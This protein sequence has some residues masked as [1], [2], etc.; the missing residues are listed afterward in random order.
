LPFIARAP[1]AERFGAVVGSGLTDVDADADADAAR[2]SMSI[3]VAV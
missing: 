1:F 2:E 3:R